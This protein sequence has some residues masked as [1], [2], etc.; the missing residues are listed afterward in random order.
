MRSFVPTHRFE[1]RFPLEPQHGRIKH[2][3]EIWD[4]QTPV[5]GEH[6]S[7]RCRYLHK[8]TGGAHE[9]LCNH[10]FQVPED[11]LEGILSSLCEV[12]VRASG[13]DPA[14]QRTIA[15]LSQR[16]VNLCVKV[17]LL[18]LES[19]MSFSEPPPEATEKDSATRG[20]GVRPY[21]ASWFH[22]YDGLFL[23]AHMRRVTQRKP[24]QRKVQHAVQHA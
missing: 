11:G 1:S 19:I 3:R 13:S 17:T 20:G 22:F 15:G 12:A 21:A 8:K 2:S 5:L 7:R 24:A 18:R 16:S 6:T 4:S 14:L 9:Y 23:Y 10:L